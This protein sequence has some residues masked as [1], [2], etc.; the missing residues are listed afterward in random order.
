MAPISQEVIT[1][2]SL[3]GTQWEQLIRDFW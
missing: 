1:L 3:V 2:V